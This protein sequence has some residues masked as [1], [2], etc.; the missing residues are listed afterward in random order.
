MPTSSRFRRQAVKLNDYILSFDH[1]DFDIYTTEIDPDLSGNNLTYNQASYHPGWQDTIHDEMR[2]I[3]KNETRDL[4]KFLPG[5][6]T[7]TMKWVYKAKPAL[8]GSAPCLKARLV[9]RGF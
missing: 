6:R 1:E 8:L 4:V 2:S 3:L 7:I 9:A 5:K